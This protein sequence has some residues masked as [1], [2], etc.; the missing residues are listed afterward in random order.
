LR[1]YD[2]LGYRQEQ[3][4]HLELGILKMVHAQRLLPLE[5]VLSQVAEAGPKTLGAAR[6]PATAAPVST[7]EAASVRK[8]E[9]PASPFEADRARKG[10]SFDPEMSAAKTNAADPEAAG[11]AVVALVEAPEPSSDA[12]KILSY[13]L[14]ELEKTGNDNLIS[15]LQ[16]GTA[17]LQG[18]ELV[19]TVS[20]PASVIPFI[21]SVEQK[22]TA[23]A[24]AAAAAGRP[25]KV[26]LESGTPAA[27]NGSAAVR[28]VANGASARSRASEESVVQRMR[29]KFGAEIR[30]VIDHRN[31]N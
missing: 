15:T 29:E 16:A 6:Q 17:T 30:T 27:G 19:V 28:P 4:F 3:R 2:D 7:S 25:I 23:N 20:Q 21:M 14:A 9:V 22:G 26:R 8:A 11:A 12:G 13:V 10:R 1:T 31:K 5:Q 24:A 18:N